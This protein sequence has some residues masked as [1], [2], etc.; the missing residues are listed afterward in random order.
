MEEEGKKE[1]AADSTLKTHFIKKKQSTLSLARTCGVSYIRPSQSV[2][3]A[4][5]ESLPPLIFQCSTSCNYTNELRAKYQGDIDKF[6]SLSENRW[7]PAIMTTEDKMRDLLLGKPFGKV[8]WVNGIKNLWPLFNEGTFLLVLFDL[9]MAMNQ[10]Q[11]WNQFNSSVFK[12]GI[13]AKKS[14]SGKKL[15]MKSIQV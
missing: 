2:Q 9:Q 3:Q 5:F 1:K 10:E 15:F 8:I 12:F 6:I 13:L 7:L 14:T 4:P 11:V